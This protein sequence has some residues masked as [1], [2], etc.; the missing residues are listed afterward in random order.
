MRHP[1]AT[2][3]GRT[4]PQTH[5]MLRLWLAGLLAMMLSGCWWDNENRRLEIVTEPAD[6]TVTA[7]ATATFSVVA[8]GKQPQYQWRRN[9]SDIANATSASHTT[10]ATVAGDSGAVYSVIVTS[11][12]R[13]L[14]SR[15]AVLTVQ[16]PPAIS[17]QPTSISVQEGQTATFSVVATGSGTLSYQWRRNGTNVSGAS[18]S[19][20]TTPAAVLADSGAQFSV[21]VSSSAGSVTSNAA[22]LT[23]TAPPPPPTAGTWGQATLLQASVAGVESSVAI[24]RATGDGVAAWTREEDGKAEVVASVYSHATNSWS[25]GVLLSSVLRQERTPEDPIS[26]PVTATNGLYFPQ[27]ALNS[28]GSIVV[29]WAQNKQRSVG[30]LG[31]VRA[32][33]YDPGTGE[34]SETFILTRI[35]GG[36][37]PT[38]TWIYG[39]SLDMDF[40]GNAM[41]A[42]LEDYGSAFATGLIAS[43]RMPA[44]GPP[45]TAMLLESLNDSSGSEVPVLVMDSAGNSTAIWLREHQGGNWDEVIARRRAA[46]SAVWG[47]PIV[48]AD[49]I[50]AGSQLQRPSAAANRSSGAVLVAWNY[51]PASGSP[52]E[53]R[54][55]RFLQTIDTWTAG[56]RVDSVAQNT[57]GTVVAVSEFDHAVVG[58]SASDG[59]RYTARAA[60]IDLASG[61]VGPNAIIDTESRDAFLMAAGIDNTGNAMLIYEQSDGSRDR[62]RARRL[63]ANNTLSGSTL[64]SSSGVW[65]HGGS[66]AVANDGTALAAWRESGTFQNGLYPAASVHG[67]AFR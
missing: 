52:Y 51:R 32:R 14:T 62:V 64:L 24:N 40:G 48:L 2:T 33:R 3:L 60:A 49:S 4:R 66:I 29:A 57:F 54:A 19:S 6:V 28:A 43:A 23:V 41:L 61:S 7:G 63:L 26:G 15:N 42:W 8:K 21:V 55:R 12:A 38:I 47:D 5:H 16:V 10:A 13:T 37:E 30:N 18:A 25:P 20:Y 34:W 22:T 39:L 50:T 53:V 36:I 31:E 17:T 46:N 35:P 44:S 56:V 11:G 9:G 59:T 65:G 45:Q 27:A 67:R 58:W 1:P